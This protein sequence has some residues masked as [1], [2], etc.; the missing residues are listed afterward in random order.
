M[1][2]SSIFFAVLVL[3]LHLCVGN[4]QNIPVNSERFFLSHETSTLFP[5]SG[6]HAIRIDNKGEIRSFSETKQQLASELELPLRDLRMIDPSFPG[7]IQA[8]FAA[9][10][11][12]ILLTLEDI[13]LI[14]KS[15]EVIVFSPSISDDS[16]FISTL[17]QQLQALYKGEIFM[18]FEH[19]VIE[20]A[21]NV[22]CNNLLQ[23]VRTLAP[24]VSASLNKLQAESRG[25]D[26]IQTQVNTA[27]S[28]SSLLCY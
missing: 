14:I 18:C 22:A 20:T 9:R 2:Q 1:L 28:C 10:P 21:L 19:V 15:N 3:F 27:V 6:F 16:E 24:A 4:I 12:A 23:K 25:L 8:A 17:Q 26:I 5:T 11:Q 13:K 7:Q